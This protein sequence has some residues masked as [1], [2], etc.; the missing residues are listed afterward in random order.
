MA[1]NAPTPT[2]QPPTAPASPGRK[3]KDGRTPAQVALGNLQTDLDLACAKVNDHP[4]VS[5]TAR[6]ARCARAGV[7]RAKVDEALEALEAA[8]ADCRE[9]TERVY[10]NP[11]KVRP[12]TRRVNLLDS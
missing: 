3:A 10:S 4:T 9:A 2:T 8:L 7:P 6:I 12:T 1:R 5:V 11:E